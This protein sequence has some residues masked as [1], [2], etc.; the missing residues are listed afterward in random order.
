MA[1]APLPLGMPGSVTGDLVTFKTIWMN[2]AGI[3][4]P[5][6]GLVLTASTRDVTNTSGTGILRTGLVM[7]WNSTSKAYTNFIIGTSS[8]NL[9][10]GGTTLTINAAGAVELVRRVGSTGT[11]TL[12]GPEAA[13]G[14]V[15]QT[16]VTYSAVNTSTGAITITGL[17]TNQQDTVR[18][19]IAST[20]GN[21]QLTVQKPDGVFVTTAS[22]AW[23][24]TDATYLANINSALDTATG[25]VGGI[26]ATAIAATDTD[27]GFVLTYSGTGYAGKSWTKA[28]V[29]LLPTS[30][31]L[32]TVVISTV[33]VQGAFLAGSWVSDVNYNTPMSL[34]EIPPWP[35]DMSL[36]STTYTDW[37]QIPMAGAIRT[38]A[39]ID[40]PTDPSQQTWLK[41]QLSTLAG[42][43]FSF[44]DSIGS[45][46]QS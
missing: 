20:G 36:I 13:S 21:V 19:N 42:N 39:I 11:F 44:S 24:A 22:A 16:T 26:V 38:A 1:I 9:A 15:R 29:A 32:S 5:G 27:L 35:S 33:A 41:T 45:G 18:F 30:S 4:K 7:A 43:K 2:G 40:Y 10:G 23:S 14:T 8:A 46:T 25:V 17:G 31:T 34:I 37:G 6:G 3:Y 28:Q 12:T